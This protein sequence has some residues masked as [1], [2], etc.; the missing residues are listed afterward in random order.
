M[1]FHRQ[2]FVF[3]PNVMDFHLSFGCLLAWLNISFTAS[4]LTGLILLLCRAG[5]KGRQG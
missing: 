3:P 4:L 2:G 1:K 5:L